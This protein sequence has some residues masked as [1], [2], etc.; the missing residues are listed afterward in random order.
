MKFWFSRERV[1]VLPGPASKQWFGCVRGRQAFPAISINWRD[2]FS[3]IPSGKIFSGI[4][5]GSASALIGTL[6]GGRR[7]L[8]QRQV[9][10]KGLFRRRAYVQAVFANEI[11]VEE[12]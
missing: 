6:G 3:A 5:E 9:D 11:G 10:K 1:F 7:N 8:R 4:A 12:G 2:H